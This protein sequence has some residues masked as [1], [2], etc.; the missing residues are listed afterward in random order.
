MNL[1]NSIEAANQREIA[2]HFIYEAEKQ[3]EIAMMYADSA[4][5]ASERAAFSEL[6]AARAMEAT[7]EAEDKLKKCK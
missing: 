4:A 3:V 1:V 2:E 7:L 5:I 6:M